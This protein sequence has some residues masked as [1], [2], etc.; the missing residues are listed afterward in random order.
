MRK[1]LCFDTIF[2]D[3][4]LNQ[5]LMVVLKCVT[6]VAIYTYIRKYCLQINTNILKLLHVV[7]NTCSSEPLVKTI[8]IHVLDLWCFRTMVFSSS[9]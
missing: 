1:K 4:N 6:E 2:R 3:I 7:N 9:F 8:F 5:V